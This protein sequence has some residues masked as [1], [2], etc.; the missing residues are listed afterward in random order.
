MEAQQL[1][2]SLLAGVL[3]LAAWL[4]LR[5]LTNAKCP[6]AYQR[7]KQQQDLSQA[8]NFRGVHAL[9]DVDTHSLAACQTGVVACCFVL[10]YTNLASTVSVI[11]SCRVQHGFTQLQHTYSCGGPLALAANVRTTALMGMHESALAGNLPQVHSLTRSS[12]RRRPEALL[13]DACAAAAL[14]DRQPPGVCG[15]RAAAGPP[16]AQPLGRAA[17][18]GVQVLYPGPLEG[19]RHGAPACCASAAPLHLL[20]VNQEH[21][22]QGALC[23]QDPALL[24]TIIGRPGLPKSPMYQ[25]FRSVRVRLMLSASRPALCTR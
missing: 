8:T 23:A 24:P 15:R 18:P 13:S 5:W 1:Y 21:A 7:V 16:G 22:S 9:L 6:G 20:P 19:R 3:G 4:T 2:W 12:V 17:G 14:P 25:Q 11:E 10:E